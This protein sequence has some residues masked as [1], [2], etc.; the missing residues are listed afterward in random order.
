MDITDGL[1]LGTVTDA[2]F[3]TA[4]G[5]V[6][7]IVT[8]TGSIESDRIRSLGYD[9]RFLR[10]WHFYLTYCEAGFAIRSLRDMQ[11][12]LSHSANDSLPE[13]PRVRPGY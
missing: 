3:D 2:E 9:E 4:T 12:V 13:F 8:D 7:R 6:V 1:V 11:I 5:M 10:R